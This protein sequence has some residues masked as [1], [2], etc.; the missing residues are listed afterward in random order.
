MNLSPYCL[1]SDEIRSLTSNY[2]E[3]SSNLCLDSLTKQSASELVKAHL[4]KYQCSS[5]G[6]YFWMLHVGN[7]EFKIYIGKTKSLERRLADYLG[8]FQ[9]HS[10]ND[11]KIRFFQEFAYRHFPDSRFSLHFRSCELESYTDI[12]SESVRQYSPLIN[13]RCNANNDLKHAIKLGFKD[14]Y[15]SVFSLKLSD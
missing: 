2:R 6:V 4:D 7:D 11:Y 3:V 12:E 15:D 8:E 1:Q 13:Q 5:L 9:I 14:Y 10:P